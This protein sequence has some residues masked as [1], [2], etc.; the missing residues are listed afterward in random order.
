MDIPYLKKDEIFKSVDYEIRTVD[1]SEW[2][3]GCVG[4]KTFD[5]Q[6]RS[7]LLKMTAEEM[8]DDWMEQV[9]VASTC[10]EKGNL[11][12]HLKIYHDYKLKTRS[13]LKKYF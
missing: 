13:A 12:L 11:I 4:V 1:V 8:P 3:G 5:G 10:D 9:I 2:W 7:S 6:T